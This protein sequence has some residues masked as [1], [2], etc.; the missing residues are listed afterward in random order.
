MSHLDVNP[1]DL[2]VQDV[3][4]YMKLPQYVLLDR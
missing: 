1:P 2:A 4:W 3:H